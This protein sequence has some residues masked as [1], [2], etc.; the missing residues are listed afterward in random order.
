M[1]KPFRS[2]GSSEKRI[3]KILKGLNGLVDFFIIAFLVL[4]VAFG[5]YSIYD[6]H[7]IMQNASTEQFETYKPKRNQSIP[8]SKLQ[9]INPEVIGW[10]HIYGTGIDYPFAQ[11]ED[12]EKYINTGI[13]GAYDLSG[14]V[15]MH[16]KNARDF[17]DYN[18]ILYGHH[19]EYHRMFGDLD[20]FEKKKFFKTH[21][22]GDVY[23][24]GKHHGVRIIAYLKADA[25]DDSVYQVVGEDTSQRQAYLDHIYEIAVHE[26]QIGTGPED[27]LLVLSTCASGAGTNQR[28]LLV[29]EITDKTYK[30]TFK[31]EE[32]SLKST[33]SWFSRWPIWWWTTGIV[34]IALL[35]V[36][37]RKKHQTKKGG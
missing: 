34:L 35:I 18:T 24:N 22:Y 36:W 7:Q 29:A 17:S 37:F 11:G 8:F 25:Y 16:C 15:F 4:L 30:N 2:S 23:Y 33:D 28:Y 13:D 32:R 27:Q 20:Q 19:M 10:I 12:D 21:K 5:I 1:R 6:N 3:R 26:R 9:K 31:E 14:A